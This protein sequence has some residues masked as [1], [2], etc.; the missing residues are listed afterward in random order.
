MTDRLS[1]FPAPPAQQASDS[2]LLGIPRGVPPI[3][4]T[5]LDAI[6]GTQQAPPA[7]APAPRPTLAERV[8]GHAVAL[9]RAIIGGGLLVAIYFAAQLLRGH[10]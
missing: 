5:T 1:A 3:S 7:P 4:T 6:F 8:H 9:H 2:R 10:L